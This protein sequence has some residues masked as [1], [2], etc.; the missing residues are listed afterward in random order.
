MRAPIRNI[1]ILNIN[2]STDNN[3]KQDTY[4][5]DVPKGSPAPIRLGLRFTLKLRIMHDDDATYDVLVLIVNKT[6]YYVFWHVMTRNTHKHTHTHTCTHTRKS[7]AARRK[8]CTDASPRGPDLK[9]SHKH[10]HTHSLK[11]HLQRQFTT[12]ARHTD[13]TTHSEL[14]QTLKCTLK[15]INVHITRTIRRVRV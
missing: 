6:S 13:S 3:Q 12:E 4:F 5:R 7:C 10:A 1:R 14:T 2:N 11:I 9:H 8:P 15:H